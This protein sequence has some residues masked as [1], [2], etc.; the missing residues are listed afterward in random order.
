M[1]HADTVSDA[2]TY[3]S[4]SQS[5]TRG[6]WLPAHSVADPDSSTSESRSQVVRSVPSVLQGQGQ[7]LQSTGAMA[8]P[9]TIESYP[10]RRD[11]HYAV[12]RLGA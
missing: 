12:I 2:A 8:G 4:A 10:K 1:T 3:R 6:S 9:L 11:W 7:R 5:R